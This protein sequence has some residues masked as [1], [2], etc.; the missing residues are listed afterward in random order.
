MSDFFAQELVV[1]TVPSETKSEEVVS[2]PPTLSNFSPAYGGNI[3]Q[4]TVLSFDITDVDSSI[5]RIIL[6]ATIQN[7]SGSE[8]I[9]DGENFNERYYSGASNVRTS[10]SNGFHYVILRDGGWPNGPGL[11][12]LIPF[13]IDIKGNENS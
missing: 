9:H 8:V 1:W 3:G 11:I 2:D 13:A 7:L 5:R 4:N 10:I 6:H 12:T